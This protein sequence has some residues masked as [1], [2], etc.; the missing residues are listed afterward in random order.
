VTAERREAVGYLKSEHWLSERRACSAVEL[1]RTAYRYA[2]LD[3]S[4]GPI[5]EALTRLA[6]KHSDLGFGKFYGM[7]R[8]KG[9]RWN[10]KRVHRVYCGMKLNKRRK[11][12]RRVPPRHPDPLVVPEDANQ[13]WSA[14]FMS[15][16]L[17]DGRRFRTFNVI[18]DHRRECLAIEIDLNLGS[19]RVIRVLDRIAE[20]RGSPQRLR[21]DNGPEFTSIA[22]ADWAE[23][24]QVELEF[25]RPGRPMQNGFIERFNRT[26]RQAVLDMYIFESLEEVRRLTAE[27]LDFYNARR[28]HD[29]LGGQPPR[30][31]YLRETSSVGIT[32][33]SSRNPENSNL[34]R[35]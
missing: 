23:A 7:L 32:V 22:V 27:W 9:H 24:N 18:D 11:F 25:I 33:T 8:Q 21:L 12:K 6:E 15:D 30:P 1:S 13:S 14:D 17:S 4:D 26:Y 31:D 16:A 5:I 3:R 34:N 20:L 10:H 28:P 19:R 2:P 29:A 35:R